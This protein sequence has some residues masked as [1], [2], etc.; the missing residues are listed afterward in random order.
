[1]KTTLVPHQDALTGLWDKTYAEE[2]INELLHQGSQGALLVIDVD[3]FNSLID[4]YG[5]IAGDNTLKMFSNTLRSFSS[6][7]DVLCRIGGDEFMVFIK[8]E[9]AKDKLSSLATNIL[10]DLHSKI[11]AY[12]FE[13]KNSISI[14]IACAPEDGDEFEALYN[15]ADKALYYVK[16]SG[17]NSYHFFSDKTQSQE[18][19][20]AKTVDLHY[21]QDLMASADNGMGVYHLDFE[22]FHY[23]YN[24]I[25]R[26]IDRNNNN[27]QTLLFTVSPKG[28]IQLDA[29]EIEYALELLEQAIYNS[30][31]RSDVTTRY[32]SKQLIVI[33]M[34][35]NNEDGD[36]VANRILDNF[37]KLYTNGKA[38]IDYGIARMDSRK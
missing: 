13:T 38:Q 5:Y 9:T 34:D 20:S 22:G 23:V 28:N 16:Q 27:V 12:G 18:N 37:N 30:L 1:M 7:K 14:G 4:N 11:Q 6:E 33:L 26:F 29:A 24:F 31:R 8:D 10:S 19:R 25:H 36:M 35:A 15:C 21:L 3:N 2:K 32:S 17:K